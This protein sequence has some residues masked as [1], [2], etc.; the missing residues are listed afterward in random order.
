METNYS[1]DDGKKQYSFGI[2]WNY[3]DE[4]R[5]GK[6]SI[7]EATYQCKRHAANCAKYFQAHGYRTYSTCACG[8]SCGYSCP[9]YLVDVSK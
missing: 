1:I 6:M 7:T 9:C 2:L 5:D 8:Y 3:A 4:I